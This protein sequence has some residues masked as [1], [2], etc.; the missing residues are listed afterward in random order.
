[1]TW[2]EDFYLTAVEDVLE[3][4]KQFVEGKEKKSGACKGV[5]IRKGGGLS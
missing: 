3:R 2:G 4:E 1:V 5:L